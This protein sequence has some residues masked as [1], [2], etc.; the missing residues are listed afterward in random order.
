M[1][2]QLQ[3]CKSKDLECFCVHFV[4]TFRRNRGWTGLL[5]LNQSLLL[6]SLFIGIHDSVGIPISLQIQEVLWLYL[7]QLPWG[8]TRRCSNVCEPGTS[9]KKLQ[10][11]DW[12]TIEIV[13]IDLVDGPYLGIQE[14]LMSSAGF[15]W[16]EVR[17]GSEVHVSLSLQ[18]LC[19]KFQ[20]LVDP[21]NLKTT[22]WLLTS[23]LEDSG[24]LGWLA[25]SAIE[26]IPISRWFQ[27]FTIVGERSNLT[28]LD[29]AR[30]D[31][32]FLAGITQVQPQRA[33]A[34]GL[35]ALAAAL[36]ARR[37]GVTVFGICPPY[38]FAMQYLQSNAQNLYL[39]NQKHC[40][41]I[42]NCG[43]KVSLGGSLQLGA[44]TEATR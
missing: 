21:H 42:S 23:F 41:V 11:K 35:C 28:L 3:S 36:A 26:T 14:S 20:A 9:K 5:P 30:F 29:S 1:C 2:Q 10:S 44:N 32:W 15:E 33:C 13:K 31:D 25:G 39:S 24:G 22:G 8:F 16:K 17:L 19:Y 43:I 37:G 38:F 12:N 27:V 40:V 7:W 6:F 18:T 4:G 34:M